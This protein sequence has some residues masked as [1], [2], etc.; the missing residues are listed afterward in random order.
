MS[1][2]RTSENTSSQSIDLNKAIPSVVEDSLNECSNN[3][4]AGSQGSESTEFSLEVRNT[5]EIGEMVG[6]QLDGCE[7][8]IHKII[9][10][11]GAVN[12]D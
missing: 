7:D 6:F 5:R 9:S 8:E 10:N 11:T 4:S 12:F 3:H 1:A 2:S